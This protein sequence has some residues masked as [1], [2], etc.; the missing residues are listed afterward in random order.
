METIVN[1]EDFVPKDTIVRRIQDIRAGPNNDRQTD[2]Y[3]G[4][5]DYPLKKDCTWEPI[6]NMYDQ[7]ELVETYEKWMKTDNEQ[8]DI[9]S[10]SINIYLKY[11]LEFELL[12]RGY[13]RRRRLFCRN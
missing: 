12:S 6:E 11:V 13:L 10:M 2:H 8:L 5:W 1:G 3:L 7:E 4:I 9:S